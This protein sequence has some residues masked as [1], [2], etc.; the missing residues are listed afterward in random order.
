MSNMNRLKNKIMQTAGYALLRIIKP[1]Q[2]QMVKKNQR[3]KD[4]YQ[5]KRCFI[6][7][8]GPS[9]NSVSFGD[10]QNEYVFTVNQLMRR[11][12]F[13]DLQSNFHL[14]SDFGFFDIDEEKEE[15]LELLSVMKSLNTEGNRPECFIPADMLNFA[16]KYGLEPELNMNYFKVRLQFYD[17]FYEKL[18]FA[19]LIPSQDCVIMFAIMLA[20]YMG[21]QEIYL[22]G[23]DTTGIAVSI[24]SVLKRNDEEDY[25]YQVSE[26]EQKRMTAMYEKRGI[27]GYAKSFWQL[28]RSY[29]II[30]QYCE[31]KGIRLVNCSETTVID[32]I[33]RMP[34]EDVLK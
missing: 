28:L 25:T 31:K 5:G 22:L 23:C 20:I 2:M 14:W 17:G 3:F 1:E 8:N 26:N 32:S 18:D 19:K 10:L 29:R 30:N 7:G 11:K 16:R 13:K 33:P 12:D 27:E 9:L 4:R 34:L 21:F 15:D 6:L 24:K